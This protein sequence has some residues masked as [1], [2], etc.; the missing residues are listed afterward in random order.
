MKKYN[1]PVCNKLIPQERVEFLLSLNYNELYC[2]DH[3]CAR[4]VK[5]IYSGENGTS[6]LIFCDRV[7]NDS[8]KGKFYDSE[9]IIDPEDVELE[10]PKEEEEL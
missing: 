1:C 2:V 3:A 6:E 8:V 5:A 10:E 9:N 4:P 7:Y